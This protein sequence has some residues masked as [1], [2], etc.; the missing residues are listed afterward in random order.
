[1]NST[2]AATAANAESVSALLPLIGQQPHLLQRLAEL[3][4]RGVE[5]EVEI[6]DCLLDA[7]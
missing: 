3:R 5:A 6:V 1:M 7:C 2:P 4:R